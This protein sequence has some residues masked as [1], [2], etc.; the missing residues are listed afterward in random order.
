METRFLV[1]WALVAQLATTAVQGESTERPTAHPADEIPAEEP[2]AGPLTG[3]VM[4]TETG[5]SL[6][7]SREPLRR[8][9]TPFRFLQGI[10]SPW[11]VTRTRQSSARRNTSC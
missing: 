11:I 2:T 1:A 10:C 3:S 8:I 7:E 5:I 6:S 9:W 4:S